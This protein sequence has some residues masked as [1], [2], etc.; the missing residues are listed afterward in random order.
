MEWGIPP[1]NHILY[2]AKSEYAVFAYAGYKLIDTLVIK[3]HKQPCRLY[4]VAIDHISFAIVVNNNNN[5]VLSNTYPSYGMDGSVHMNTSNILHGCIILILVFSLCHV[6]SADSALDFTLKIY[7]NA[8]MDEDINDLD[9]RYAE[10]IIAGKEKETK[11]ADAN[12]DG[13]IDEADVALI[14]QIIDKTASSIIIDDG[15]DRVVTLPYPSRNIVCMWS[16]IAE[17]IKAIG[18]ADRIIAIDD[19]TAKRTVLLPDISKLTSV[20]TS[21]EPDIEKIISLKP[22]FVVSYPLKEGLISKLESAGIPT[23]GYSY[24][25]TKDT[26]YCTGFNEAKQLGFLLD[27]REG[28]EKYINFY[29]N[30]LFRVEDKVS[31]LSTSDRP[32][33]LYMYDFSDGQLKSS[34]ANNGMNYMITFA[35]GHDITSESPGDFIK[36][37][38]EFA[39]KENPEFVMYESDVSYKDTSPLIGY[40]QSDPSRIQKVLDEFKSLPGFDSID[41][42]KNNKVYAMPWGIISHCQWLATLYQAKLYNPGLFADLDVPSIHKEYL[43]KFL[44]LDPAVYAGG[45]YLYPY[46]EGW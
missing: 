14:R 36:L 5:K 27:S 30:Y 12:N 39:I 33:V 35:G 28:A 25:H 8:N 46:P 21:S 15:S 44:G 16:A 43:E 38:P 34:G 26:T 40:G 3:Y 29:K 32:T 9:V 45:I 42:V 23:V 18:A 6:V 41:A 2:R 22:D 7:G 17:P 1:C 19:Q 24:S 10:Q 31:S 4:N 37:D 13:T 20:G 11:Y